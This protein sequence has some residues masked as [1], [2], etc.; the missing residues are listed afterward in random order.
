MLGR[1]DMLF[2]CAL[3]TC[4]P[5]SANSS[6]LPF[7]S[8]IC[9][10]CSEC[11]VGF[12][13]AQAC[14]NGLN[15]VCSACARCQPGTEYQTSPCEPTSDRTCAAVSP[16][17]TVNEYQTKAPTATS[18][19]MC[20]PL[21]GEQPLTRLFVFACMLVGSCSR[22]C[23]V[24][25]VC[26]PFFEVEATAASKMTDRVCANVTCPAGQFQRVA[27]TASSAQYAACVLETC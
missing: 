3:I 7:L 19:R 20:L 11:P 8:R 6:Y 18:D 9:A 16:V 23:M 10:P 22:R 14:A 21:T 5:V 2:G 13:A 4:N 12:H 15:T 1:L 26:R 27:P 25:T 17:C 24:A